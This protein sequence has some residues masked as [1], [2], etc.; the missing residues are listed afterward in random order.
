MDFNKLKC[1]GILLLTAI[2]WGTAFVFQSEG[3]SHMGP[4]TFNAARSFLGSAALAPIVLICYFYRKKK[5]ESYPLKS[6]LLGGLCCGLTLTAATLLQQFGLIYTTVGKGGFITAL[7]IIF[8]PILAVFLGKKPHFIV[9]VSAAIAAVG[10]YLLCMSGE[11]L[12]VSKGDVLVLLCAIIYSGYILIVDYFSDKTDNIAMSSIQFFVC[13]VLSGAGALIFEQP[14]FSQLIDGGISVLYVGIMSS[15][16]AYTLQIVGQR[17][18]NPTVAALIMSLEAVI[19]AVS[20]YFA[21]KIGFIKTD[22]SMSMRQIFG[23]LLMFSAVV[24]VQLPWEKLSKKRQS[25]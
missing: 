10:L 13:F 21:Y 1:S 25:S 14:T 20:G 15:G 4:I 6:T 17:G 22:Q 19:S 7:Y 9:W 8:T 12:S 11:D 2:I 18:L 16:V 3:N 23:C 5:G 24:L